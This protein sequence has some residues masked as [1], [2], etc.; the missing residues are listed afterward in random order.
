MSAHHITPLRSYRCHYHPTD[1]AGI[2]LQNDSGTLPFVQV[3]A[4]STDS[5][6]TLAAATVKGPIVNVER[7][8]AAD[9]VAA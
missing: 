3:K 1:R 8:E 4:A 2:P 9:E 7:I 5:A 6:R